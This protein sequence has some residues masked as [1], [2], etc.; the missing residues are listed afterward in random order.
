MEI[1]QNALSFIKDNWIAIGVVYL[2]LHKLLVTIRDVLDK[3]PQTDD[4]LF[5][6]L[7]SVMGKLAKYFTTG[8]RPK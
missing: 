4:N 1:F 8:A 3:T 5:E 2:A 6:K 7:V